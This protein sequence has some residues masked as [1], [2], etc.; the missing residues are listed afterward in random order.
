MKKR[1]HER[2]SK[3]SEEEMKKEEELRKMIEQVKKT[4]VAEEEFEGFSD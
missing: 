2:V 3:L 1:E 4:V